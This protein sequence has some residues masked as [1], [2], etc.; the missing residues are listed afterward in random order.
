MP[1]TNVVIVW[2]SCCWASP[3]SQVCPSL[4]LLFFTTCSFLCN[5]TCLKP[6]FSRLCIWHMAELLLGKPIF[7]GSAFSFLPFF[8]TSSLLCNST[9][10]KPDF[11]GHVSDTWQ[12]CCWANPFPGLPF[13][14]PSLLHYLF[15]VVQQYIPGTNVSRRCV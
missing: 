9:C 14:F 4:S 5:S 8:T 3:F 15:I 6:N 7:P 13:S 1:E 10:L 12:S 11:T 2:Q